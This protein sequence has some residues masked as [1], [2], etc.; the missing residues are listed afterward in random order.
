[1]K[2]PLVAVVDWKK[3]PRGDKNCTV[4]KQA[5]GG[6]AIVKYYT[7]NTVGDWKGELLRA[8]AILLWHNTSMPDAVVNKL[9]NCKA[10]IRIGTGYDSV[11]HLTAAT[12]DIPVCNVPDYGTDEV[13]D[14]SI[15]LALALCRQIIPIN[16][17]CK[18]LGWEI[19]NKNKIQR[20]GE[21]AFGV[22]G[23]G[24]I[25]TSV[26]LKAKALGFEV[27]FYDPYL[28]NGVDK[29]L[30]IARQ[31]DFNEFLSLMDVI[32][33]NCPLTE[34]THHMITK[35]EI[36]KMRKNAF[37]VNTARGSIIKKNDL[38]DALR[39]DKIAGAALDV[40]EDE[41]LKT[42]KEAETPNLIVTCHS[43]FYSLQAA[44]EMRY[45][46]ATQAKEIIQGGEIQNCINCRNLPRNYWNI[47]EENDKI[48][49]T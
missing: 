42:K 17:E 3:S 1:M 41:P 14:H 36:N 18:N 8:D 24:R 32:S 26:A 29:S 10:I 27:H 46:A 15:A 37:I 25:G 45:K 2:K 12:R 38:F 44:W 22:I 16:Q 6:K 39:K 5:I 49:G 48:R 20:F 47:M 43:G 28:S 30:G 40:I 35:K 9:E 4:E 33:I 19:P 23:L 13:A 31:K 11:D 34:E 21:M 7:C